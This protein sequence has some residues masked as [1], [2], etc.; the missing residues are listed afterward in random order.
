M[1]FWL[2]DRITNVVA[3]AETM[4]RASGVTVTPMQ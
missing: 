2:D 1:G 3:L 4:V